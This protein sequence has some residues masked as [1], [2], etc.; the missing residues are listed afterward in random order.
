MENGCYYHIFNRSINRELLFRDDENY[1]YFLRRYTDYLKDEVETYSYCLMPTHFHFLIRVKE[2]P[3]QLQTT[4]VSGAFV[5]SPRAR[6]SRSLT[7]VEKAFR[8]FFISYA[9]SFNKR[10]ERT[11]SLFQ[12]KFKRKE[13]RDLRY[14]THLVYYIHA[15]PI[16]ANLCDLFSDWI[17]SSYNA[18]L[19]S[20]PT[21]LQRQDVLAWFDSKENFIVAHKQGLETE[22]I[23]HYLFD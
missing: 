20:Q 22:P 21:M 13:I 7:P 6:K 23:L 4:N 16:K 14:L 18:I 11:G 8:D 3:E 17:F 1:R 19:S 2:N 5:V 9:K 12:Y 10:Y 15:N